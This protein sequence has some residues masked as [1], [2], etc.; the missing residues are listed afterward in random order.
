MN[1]GTYGTSEAGHSVGTSRSTPIYGIFGKKKQFSA[2]LE[3][4]KELKNGLNIGFT[5]AF[6]AGELY[7]NSMA[8]MFS[9]GKKF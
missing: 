3:T 4:N 7:Y 1:Y 6:D 8:A 9:V 5:G 2:L